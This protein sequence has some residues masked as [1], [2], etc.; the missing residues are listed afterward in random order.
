MAA[1]NKSFQEQ[2][3]TELLATLDRFLPEYDSVLT[4]H[5]FRTVAEMA[6]RALARSSGQSSSGQS[7][8]NQSGDGPA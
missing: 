2:T 8:S 4:G 1:E 6:K 7:S 5:A 3:D